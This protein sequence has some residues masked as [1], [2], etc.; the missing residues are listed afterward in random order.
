MLLRREVKNEFTKLFEGGKRPTVREML[1]NC[2]LKASVAADVPQLRE[3]MFPKDG[4]KETFDELLDWALTSKRNREKNDYMLNRNARNCLS[5][6]AKEFD[7]AAWNDGRLKARLKNFFSTPEAKD[8][9]F[10]GH[11][12]SIYIRFAF[13]TDGELVEQD[14]LLYEHLI[15]RIN[16][17]GYM[18][19][20]QDLLANYA[21]QLA[22]PFGGD[23]Q[24]LILDMFSRALDVARSGDYDTVNSIFRMLIGSLSAGHDIELY[25]NAATI[26]AILRVAEYFTGKDKKMLLAASALFSFLS[27]VLEPVWSDQDILRRVSEY[28][29]TFKTASENG[30]PNKDLAY[31]AFPVIYRWGLNALFEDVFSSPASPTRF[32]GSSFFI[33]EYVP[34]FVALSDDELWEIMTPKRIENIIKFF[35]PE[36]RPQNYAAVL[37]T[38]RIINSRKNPPSNLNALLSSQEWGSVCVKVL[39]C[40]AHVEAAKCTTKPY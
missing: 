40:V 14:T 35:A 19:L 32:E 33:S 1:S 5:V 36:T 34:C 31:V 27:K 15:E 17:L 23:V 16:T 13:C 10:A 39:D 29:N 24:K 7:K 38:N 2:D 21:D 20:A 11:Y 4:S 3:F 6:V 28:C 8:P 12:A 26:D 25:Q 30:K 9:M 18:V 37:I 22:V